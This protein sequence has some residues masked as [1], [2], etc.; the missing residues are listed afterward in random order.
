MLVTKCLCRHSVQHGIQ[1][2]VELTECLLDVSIFSIRAAGSLQRCIEPLQA[3]QE[4]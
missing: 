3:V 4:R 1:L 2:R